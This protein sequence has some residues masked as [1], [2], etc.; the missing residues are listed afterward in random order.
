M[1][2]PYT[3]RQALPIDAQFLLETKRL[4][5]REYVDKMGQWS[6]DIHRTKIAAIPLTNIQIIQVEDK[7]IGWFNVTRTRDHIELFDIYIIPS[8]Q[9]RKIGTQIVER[10]MKEA[11]A[12]RV[13]F[14]LVVLKVNPEARDLYIKLGMKEIGQTDTHHRLT[15]EPANFYPGIE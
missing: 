11:A 7:A 15:C 5:Y 6:D 4:A 8:Y 1:T 13:A 3:T 9:R 10:L 2:L 12:K 14:Q